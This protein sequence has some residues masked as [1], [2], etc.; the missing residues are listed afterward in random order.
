MRARALVVPLAVMMLAAC[1]TPEPGPTTAPA[2][3]PVAESTPEEIATEAEATEPALMQLEIGDTFTTDLG[4]EIT[5]HEVRLDIPWDY[6]PDDGGL[7]HAADIEYCLGETPPEPIAF[8]DFTWSW[9]MRTSEGYVLDHP[10]SWEDA[11]ISPL[12]DL[13][14]TSP[15]S[16]ECYRGWVLF[17]GPEDADVTSVRF[18]ELDWSI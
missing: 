5:V 10:S 17:D 3:V 9:V 15:V 13:S 8:Q 7:W 11:M 16:G 14:Q 2:E 6:P 18:F 4:S 1:S 12:L